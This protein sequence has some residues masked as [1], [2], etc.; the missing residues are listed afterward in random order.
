MLKIKQLD[1]SQPTRTVTRFCNTWGEHYTSHSQRQYHVDGQGDVWA[2]YA[3]DSFMERGGVI[4]G[5]VLPT[6]PLLPGPTSIP[7]PQSSSALG[8][9]WDAAEGV[10]VSDMASLPQSLDCNHRQ[11]RCQTDSECLPYWSNGPARRARYGKHGIRS[12]YQ[13]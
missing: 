10:L 12:C 1:C 2:N 5:P 9:T 4:Q 8:W 3:A 13:P 7:V 6:A 11:G